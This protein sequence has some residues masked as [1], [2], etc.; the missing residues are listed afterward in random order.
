L[1]RRALWASSRRTLHEVSKL[2]TGKR[3]RQRLAYFFQRFN[4]LFNEF[5]QL[6]KHLFGIVAMATA[7]YG[8]YLILA[9]L[10]PSFPYCAICLVVQ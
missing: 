6:D 8:S 3:L 4:C 5:A 9:R 2:A 10:R 7:L 1:D